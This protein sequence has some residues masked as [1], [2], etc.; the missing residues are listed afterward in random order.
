MTEKEEDMIWR[1]K[2]PHKA[3]VH[4]DDCRIYTADPTVWIEW[5]ELGGGHWQAVCVCGTQDY[6]EPVAGR[7]RLDPLDAKT[8]RHAPQCEFASETDA[9]MLRVILKVKDGAGG[10]YWWVTCGSCDTGWQVPHYG[11]NVAT[12]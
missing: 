1:R 9:A 11:E 3:F 8:S 5:S 4:S 2:R 10:D 7:V 12:R 6:Y